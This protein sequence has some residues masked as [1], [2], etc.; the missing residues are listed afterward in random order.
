[1]KNVENTTLIEDYLNGDLPEQEAKDFE[2]KLETEAELAEE[3]ALHQRIRSFTAE[4]EIQK[5]KNQVKG[6]LEEEAQE[7]PE[8]AGKTIPLNPKIKQNSWVSGIR[9]AASVLVVLGLGWWYFATKT[10]TVSGND[11]LAALIAKEPSN[12]QG[13]DDRSLWIAAYR[14][15]D[16]EKVISLLE[17]KSPKT[18]EE[19]YYLGLSYAAKADFEKAIT[20][21]DS[22]VIADSAYTEKAAWAM[23][24]ILLKQNR[25]TEAKKLLEKIANSDSEF[26]EKAKKLL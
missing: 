19:Q 8:T 18:S 4:N 17:N 12:L 21:F 10:D 2:E 6:W 7:K 26:N 9:I 24:L 23:A 15:K 13:N 11:Q 1:M 20:Q 14:A 16:Y 22:K 25:Q 3:M 5:L